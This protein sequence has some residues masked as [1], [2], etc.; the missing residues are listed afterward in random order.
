VGRRTDALGYFLDSR[1]P[2]VHDHLEAVVLLIALLSGLPSIVSMI[3]VVVGRFR[4]K[5]DAKRQPEIE[6]A[7]PA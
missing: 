3:R 4:R 6:I 7:D 2:F 1:F 5:A